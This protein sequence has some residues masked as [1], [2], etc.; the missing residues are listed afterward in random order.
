MRTIGNLPRLSI[1]RELL[2]PSIAAAAGA[3]LFSA[4][5][6][7]WSGLVLFLLWLSISLLL[8]WRWAALMLSLGLLLHFA[9]KQ[10]ND[11][12]IALTSMPITALDVHITAG[13]S[14]V[15]WHLFDLPQWSRLALFLACGVGLLFLLVNIIRRI[16]LSFS[17]RLVTVTCTTGMVCFLFPHF[18][19]KIFGDVRG[20]LAATD[21]P[22]GLSITD[23]QGWG[24]PIQMWS[25]EG[26]AQ[27]SSQIGPFP[28]FLYSYR[29]EKD[30]GAI[31][32][33]PARG[34][35]RTAE[36]DISEA[37]REYFSLSSNS[38]PN[39]VL[40]HL[41]SIFNPNW[42]FKLD[43]KVASFLFERND[44]SRLLLPMRVNVV[45]G[46]SWVTEFEVLTGL[47][48]RLFGYSGYYSHASVGPHISGGFPA[49]LQR[50]GYL[51]AAFYPATGAFVN[52]RKAYS[53]YGFHHF[54][55]SR[56]L[57]LSHEWK[58]TDV[59]LAESFVKKSASFQDNAFFSFIVTNGAHSPYPCRNFTSSALFSVKFKENDNAVLNCELNE[60]V[61]LM[62]KAEQA[63]RLV[64]AKLVQIQRRTSRPFVLMVYG[65][66][67]PHSFTRTW[68]WVQGDYD[69]VRTSASKNQTFVHVFSSIKDGKKSLA[70]E[71]P[72]SL[73]PTVLSSFVANGPDDLYMAANLLLYR[74]CGS[75]LYPAAPSAGM[76]GV[77]RVAGAESVTIGVR[78]GAPNKVT[79]ACEL[80]QD[81]TIGS[82]RA[83]GIL[84]LP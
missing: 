67:Q 6:W 8:P 57:E 62:R 74:T 68:Q 75:D 83:T 3:L 40:M 80:A 21:H 13:N 26:V 54:W 61:L 65:D 18:A 82:L 2:P 59:E 28:F 33:D 31:F 48:Y 32:F 78:V 70:G 58:T 12:K 19:D 81:R 53:H 66:H 63:V 30:S 39:I 46:G 50:R 37:A 55:D 34:T 49:Y 23:K 16:R 42:A 22:W 25:P 45:G 10:A 71:L 9:L 79:I 51:T 47:D 43:R 17:P 77:D 29:L 73:L 7:S 60:Y 38:Q 56:D 11:Y 52:A 44:M 41:E 1:A 5:M 84:K 35:Q 69:S 72:A 64:L 20:H 14:A 4:S 36:S 76:F 27:V 24:W 15:L